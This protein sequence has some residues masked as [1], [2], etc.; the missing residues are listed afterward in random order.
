MT[1]SGE[2]FPT[3]GGYNGIVTYGGVEASSVV[4]LSNSQI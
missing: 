1:L 3:T 4:I 2:N